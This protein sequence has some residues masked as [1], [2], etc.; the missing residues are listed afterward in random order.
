M[1][2]IENSQKRRKC[3]GG[4]GKT[5]EQ[6]EEQPKHPKNSCFD[7][8]GCFSG[9]FA[10][11]LPTLCPGPPWHLSRLFAAVGHASVDGR[12]DCNCRAV[13][14]ENVMPWGYPR[15]SV[16]AQ[17]L[18]AFGNWI[19]QVARSQEGFLLGAESWR[20][21]LCRKVAWNLGS[22][23]KSCNGIART[24]SGRFWDSGGHL[25]HLDQH[26]YTYLELV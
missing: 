26:E 5:A 14:S 10:A 7:C 17:I 1:P 3:R 18:K 2:E 12:R 20:C 22:H 6:P 16:R 9:C 21:V 15:H 23:P 19:L 25:A 4:H 11:V 13:L 24:A 8:F